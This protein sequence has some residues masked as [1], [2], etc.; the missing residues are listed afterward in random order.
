MADEIDDT[1]KLSVEDRIKKLKEIEKRN[2]EEI[3]KAQDL[4][5]QS[6]F[7]LED[8]EKEKASTPIP[9]LK[10]VDIGELFTE[11]EKQLFK[12]KRYEEKPRAGKEALEDTVAVEEKKLTPEQI[13]QAQHQYRNQLSKEPVNQ[14]YSKIKNIYQNVQASGT[15][16]ADQMGQITNIEYALDKKKQ[17]IE[18]GEYNPSEYAA[19][20]LVSTQ[21]IGEELKRKYKG[22]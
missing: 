2:K 16:S 5:K 22:R 17:D 3:Q 20:K 12:T 8:K 7:E 21:Q 10:A 18:S 1:K 11:E 4:L 15:M 9:Q 14:L 13:E 19:H 6:E